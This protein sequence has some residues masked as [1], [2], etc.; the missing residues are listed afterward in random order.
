MSTGYSSAAAALC[1]GCLAHHR[2][3]MPG[4]PR[5]ATFA[6][7]EGARVRYEDV[8]EGPP[9]VLVHGDS[10]YFRI[11]KP[12]G[13]VP[14]GRAATEVPPIENFTRVEPFGFTSHHWIQVTVDPDDREVF[15]FRQRIVEKNIYKRQ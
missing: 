3:A 8:G 9:V 10:H 5:R 13:R 4:E 12:L 11:D 2:G 6:E 14:T 1:A 15:T 7:I